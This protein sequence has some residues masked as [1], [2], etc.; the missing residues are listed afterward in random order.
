MATV[1]GEIETDTDDWRSAADIDSELD[2]GNRSCI[3]GPPG[4]FSLHPPK[5]PLIAFTPR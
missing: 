2:T 4:T 3:E 5:L 1:D